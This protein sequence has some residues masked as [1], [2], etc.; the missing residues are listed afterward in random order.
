MFFDSI[1]KRCVFAIILKLC[2]DELFYLQKKRRKKEK[3]TKIIEDN[4]F[5]ELFELA[6]EVLFWLSITQWKSLSII[7]IFEKSSL[8][9]AFSWIDLQCEMPWTENRELST[10]NQPWQ[11]DSLVYVQLCFLNQTPDLVI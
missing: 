3:E 6:S 4:Y 10:K 5:Y 9:H 2:V 1:I 11:K 7:S 8:F